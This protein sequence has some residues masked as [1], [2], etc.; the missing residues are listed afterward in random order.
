VRHLLASNVHFRP[1][2]DISSIRVSTPRRGKGT[3]RFTGRSPAVDTEAEKLI[4]KAR[5]CRDL[6]NLLH[7]PKATFMLQEMAEECEQYAARRK[8]KSRGASSE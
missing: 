6:A 3:A 2:A 7:D 5:Q 8:D 4:L 1:I